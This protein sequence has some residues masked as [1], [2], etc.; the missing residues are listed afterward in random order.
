VKLPV[1]KKVQ[2]ASSASKGELFDLRLAIEQ[3]LDLAQD[4]SDHPRVRLAR[5]CLALAIDHWHGR[6]R[7]DVG[8][9]RIAW[10]LDALD[11]ASERARLGYDEPDDDLLCM[12]AQQIANSAATLEPHGLGRVP[13]DAWTDALRNWTPHSDRS[14][15]P[16]N[17]KRSRARVLHDIFRKH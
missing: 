8:R 14:G 12:R 11:T 2:L 15:A 3:L 10:A 6:D 7:A 13:V 17:G 1:A 5:E 9:M 16:T 4:G